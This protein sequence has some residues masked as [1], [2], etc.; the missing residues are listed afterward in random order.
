MAPY[1]KASPVPN[2][3]PACGRALTGH[4]C[5]ETTLR[6]TGLKVILTVDRK[7]ATVS[8]GSS[9][10]LQS[11]SERPLGSVFADVAGEQSRMTVLT[12]F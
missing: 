8:F 12:E 4:S 3:A 2:I 7:I 10:Y 1:C 11:V 6:M 9:P 5:S